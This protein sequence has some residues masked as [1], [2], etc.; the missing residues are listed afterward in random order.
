MDAKERV[1]NSIMYKK[2][3]RL[4]AGLF[5]TSCEYLKGLSDY[6]GTKS[7]EELFHHFSIDIWDIDAYISTKYKGGQKR[8]LGRLVNP[9]EELYWEHNPNPP[10]SQVS[11]I[12]EVGMYPFPTM[13]D[14]DFATLEGEVDQHAEF[15]L[16]ACAN[17]AI[18]HNYLY[19]CGQM[20]GLCLLKAEPE[21]ANAIIVRITDFWVE[22]LESVLKACEG[23]AT[24]VE[25][26]NDFGTQR[27]MFISPEDFRTFFKPQLKRLYGIAHKYGVYAVQHSC[28]AIN[29]IIPDFIESG[30]NVINPIQVS[31]EGMELENVVQKYYGNVAFYGGIDTQYLLPGGS[32]EDVR[33]GVTKAVSLFNTNGGYILSGSQGLMNDIPYANAAA[34]LDPELRR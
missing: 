22:Y 12:E 29:P 14:F 13:E 34:M 28:G 27:S 31:A 33:K 25:N 18:F 20:N 21:V 23:K 10:F 16:C 11:S 24:L 1:I 32:V 5:G 3:D 2:V 30:A 4:P 19:M 17:A 8:Y 6:T 7:I 9:I 26:C 15:A